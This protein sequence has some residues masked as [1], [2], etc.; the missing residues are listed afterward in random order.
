MPPTWRSVSVLL[1]DGERFP[2]VFLQL[3]CPLRRN[4]QHL[5]FS[6]F[7]FFPFLLCVLILSVLLSLFRPAPAVLAALC[8]W[9]AGKAGI[10]GG[11]VDWHTIQSAWKLNLWQFSVIHLW[12]HEYI[13]A[14]FF[15]YIQNLSYSCCVCPSANLHF[16][17]FHPHMHEYVSF[18]F[19]FLVSRV[20]VVSVVG[21]SFRLLPIIS[22]FFKV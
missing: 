9:Q 2:P 22:R 10:L 13:L 5:Y 18:K 15:I 12:H 19:S 16:V 6:F 7:L 21:A 20:V 14:L 1:F 8:P 17:L 3:F 4:A 11:T